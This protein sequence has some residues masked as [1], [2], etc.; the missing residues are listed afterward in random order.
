MQGP[1]SGESRGTIVF[2]HGF[3]EF[4]YGWKNQIPEFA[5]DHRVVAPDLRG[6]NLSD[7]PEGVEAYTVKQIAADLAGLVDALGDGPVVMVAHDWGGAVAWLRDE[8]DMD[9][10]TAQLEEEGIASFAKSYD[11]LL[12]GV[13]AKRSQLAGA[14]AD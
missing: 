2:V 7:K 8:R 3:P 10:V 9:A 1:E 14:A 12:E 13:A 11:A 5:K 4:W 6:Y